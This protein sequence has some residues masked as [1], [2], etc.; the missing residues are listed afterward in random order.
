LDAEVIDAPFPWD[1]TKELGSIRVGYD[2]TAFEEENPDREL[3]DASLDHLKQL[4][5]DPQPVELPDLPVGDMLFVLEA[6]AAAAFD[7]LTRS[8]R[9]DLLVRQIEQA[10][11]NVFRT[12]RL[13]PAVEYIQANRARTLLMEQ[14][15]RV[16]DGVDVYVHPTYGGNTLLSTNL[17]GHPSV[18]VPNGFRKD[19]TP[20]SITFTGNLFR[21]H[22]LLRVALAYQNRT[23][24]HKRRPDLG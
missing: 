8:G 11:P 2:P 19:G 20:S 6:E 17:T 9:D 5:F 14:Y 15:E 18:I 10:W 24:F 4:G 22:E 21:E 13:I 16:F 3:Q 23:G 12:A 7:D 1:A